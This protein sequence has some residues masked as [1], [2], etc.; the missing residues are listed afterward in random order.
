MFN[1]DVV[2]NSI[3]K[4]RFASETTTNRIFNV[5][6]RSCVMD[7]GF[8]FL[9]TKFSTRARKFAK[10]HYFGTTEIPPYR[11]RLNYGF[12]FITLFC[13]VATVYA[14]LPTDDRFFDGNCAV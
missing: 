13:V 9:R 8:L 14:G 10:T 11:V 6:V 2:I 3:R 5:V 4:P 12:F 7:F 1:Y